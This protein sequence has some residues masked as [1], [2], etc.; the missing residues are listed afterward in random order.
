MNKQKREI[1]IKRKAK[2]FPIFFSKTIPRVND[3]TNCNQ[4]HV[5][6]CEV[7]PI[8]RNKTETQNWNKRDKYDPDRALFQQ[9]QWGHQEHN[10]STRES[11][12]NYVATTAH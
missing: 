8:N 3:L 9:E 10:A 4:L 12:V 6:I 5:H 1:A 7:L 2:R 11:T